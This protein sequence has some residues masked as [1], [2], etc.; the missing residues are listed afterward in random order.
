MKKLT[1]TNH[2][3]RETTVLENEFIDHYM[4][5]A[6]G[7]YV[8]V[9]LLL[10]RHLNAPSGTLTI[11]RIADLLDH[12]EK[13]VIRALNYWKK[14]GL[15][16]YEDTASRKAASAKGSGSAR[17]RVSETETASRRMSETETGSR[18][19]SEAETAS[20]RDS[21]TDTGSRRMPETEAGLRRDPGAE[22]GPRRMSEAETGLRR[23]A[24]A[25]SGSRRMSESETAPR[26]IS[27]TESVP[28]RMSG[29][30]SSSSAH[31]QEAP[32][33]QRHQRTESDAHPDAAS[34]R[35]LFARKEAFLSE[36]YEPLPPVP[37]VSNLQ[38]YKSR[39]EFKEL[40]FVAEQY[41][42]K[43]LS[44]TDIETIAYFYETLHM[45]L[46]LTEY[47]IE[48][49]VENGHK[50]MHYIRKVAL[51]WHER[52]IS[53]VAEAKAGSLS[54]NRNCY[55]VL[56]A[57][58]IKGRSPAASE[59][60]YIKKWTEEYGFSL[61]IIVEAC[62]KT[63]STIHQPSFDY[64]DTILRDWL[65]KKVQRLEDIKAI[66]AGFLKEKE[67]RKKQTSK[68]SASRNKFNNFEGRSY[69][70]NELERKLI[71]Q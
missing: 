2:V 64:A 29:A 26:R 51:S 1:L 67:R 47:L 40:L 9:Y 56:N 31:M 43:T 16:E 30:E 13:D 69:D 25:E 71:Q 65:S 49:C 62:N 44:S 24:E 52:G 37:E 19:M 42:G 5:K 50:S 58:G 48:Y 21:G 3:Q 32:A 34:L 12:T 20:R 14:Q 18:R 35:D 22:T 66:D 11:S 60:T 68:A 46:D 36:D 61:E 70:M 59:L 63:I 45:S 15:L 28:Q 54:Y 55:S 27:D 8:K 33:A 39:K 57:F 53:T 10:L 38:Q 7:E 17:R 41:L 23:M 4:A 6:N